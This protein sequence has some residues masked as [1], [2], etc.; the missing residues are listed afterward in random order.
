MANYLRRSMRCGQSYQARQPPHKLERPMA[1]SD[2]ECKAVLRRQGYFLQWPRC[3]EAPA[4]KHELKAAETA[5]NYS[6]VPWP[7]IA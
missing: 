4:R 2:A 1:F 6:A 5:P 3:Q 7:D